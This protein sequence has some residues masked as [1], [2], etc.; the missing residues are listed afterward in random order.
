MTVATTSLPQG[1]VGKSYSGKVTATGGKSSLKCS[2]A[3]GALPTGMKLTSSGRL[4]GRLTVA[5]S[6]DVTLKV[7]DNTKPTANV[8]TKAFTIVVN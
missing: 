3:A 1:T 6:Y 8:A 4:S 5:G 2:V 7:T